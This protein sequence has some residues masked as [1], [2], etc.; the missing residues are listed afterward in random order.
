M[1]IIYPFTLLRENGFFKWFYYFASSTRSNRREKSLDQLLKIYASTCKN[2]EDVLNEISE[3]K[4]KELDYNGNV[5][6]VEYMNVSKAISDAKENEYKEVVKRTDLK[7]YNG[8]QVL[9]RI[10]ATNPLREELNWGVD[11]SSIVLNTLKFCVALRN[12]LERSERV[13]VIQEEVS[14]LNHEEGRI[15]GLNL[16]DS[17]SIE[18]RTIQADKYV[19]CAG[20]YSKEIAKS[21]G[22]NI[23][24]LGVKGYSVNSKTKKPLNPDTAWGFLDRY[25]VMTPLGREGRFRVTGF[26]D[27]VGS[28]N[29]DMDK[30]RIQ[31]I[32]LTAEQVGGEGCIDESSWWCGHRPVSPDDVPMVGSSRYFKNLYLN[33]GHGA[34]GTT[35]SVPTAMLLSDIMFGLNNSGLDASVC[36]PK[37]FNV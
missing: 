20:V 7:F 35:G 30:E 24:V 1:S 33:T 26:V 10:K 15:T 28:F 32:R 8:G 17:A 18:K 3:N 14:G 13:T 19:L 29:Y 2:L 12:Y 11:S 16:K 25:S 21:V 22:L 4:E 37:R 31:K 23:P 5:K 27:M 6:L 9:E 36:S 34:R